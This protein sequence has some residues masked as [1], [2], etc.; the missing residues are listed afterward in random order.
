MDPLLAKP[1]SAP[2]HTKELFVKRCRYIS[3]SIQEESLEI[4]GE[5]LTVQD[6]IDL[7][8]PLQKRKGV[9]AYCEK[10]PHLKRPVGSLLAE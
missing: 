2:S 7:K 9:V 6:M 1:K 5:F 8:F 10:R 3:E 4:E